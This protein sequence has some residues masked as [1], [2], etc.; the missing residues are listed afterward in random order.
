MYSLIPFAVILFSSSAFSHTFIWGVFVNGVDQGTFRGIRLPAYNGAPNAGGYANSPVKN[1]TSIDMRCNVMGDIQAPDT[2][3]VAPG[4]NLTFDWHHNSRTLT[5]DVIAS[6]HHGPAMIYISPDPPTE[7]SF[8]KIW[9]EGLYSFGNW[10]TTEDIA[11]NGGHMNVRVPA[12]LKAGYYLIRAEMVGLHEANVAYDLNPVRG[13][14]FYPDCVQIEVGG[15]GTVELPS[16]VSFPGAYSYEDPGIVYDVYCSTA[17]PKPTTTCTTTYQIP[18]P[19]VWSGAWSTTTSISLSSI[20]GPT[21]ATPWS[22]WIQ[23]SIVTSAEYSTATDITVLGSSLYQ[24]KWSSTY[25]TPDPT[26]S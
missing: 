5:D 13:A 17:T 21:T 23:K 7:N 4:D 1:L 3:K 18:G 26:G 11:K 24:A 6:S 2:I 12:G 19:T 10:A 25:Q 8:V 16:G 9:E 15:D 22:T 20:A 14:Q